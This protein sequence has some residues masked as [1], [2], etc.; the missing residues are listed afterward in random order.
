VIWRG[1][2][3]G[4]SPSPIFQIADIGLLADL[5]AAAPELTGKL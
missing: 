5:F 1:S 2:G 4:Y 3:P